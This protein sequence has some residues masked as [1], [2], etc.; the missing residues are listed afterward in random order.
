MPVRGRRERGELPRHIQMTLRIFKVQ[1]YYDTGRTVQG[2][3]GTL[4]GVRVHIPVK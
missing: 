3:G 1:Q 4:Q 2:A